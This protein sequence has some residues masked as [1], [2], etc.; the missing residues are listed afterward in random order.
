MRLTAPRLAR[1]AAI[2]LS[3]SQAKAYL[4]LLDL[5]P[6]R[7]GDV[8]R[9]A[10][11]PRTR[12]YAVFAELHALGLVD[13]QPG[14]PVLYAARTL[15]GYLRRRAGTLQSEA[16]KLEAELPSLTREFAP[17]EEG[18][19]RPARTRFF[20]GRASALESVAEAIAQ[21]RESIVLGCSAGTLER[22]AAAQL[23]RALTQRVGEGLQLDVVLPPRGGGRDPLAGFSMPGV[24]LRRLDT[25]MPIEIWLL[26]GRG[27]L[28]WAPH[29][30]DGEVIE[31]E[32]EGLVSANAALHTFF[33]SALR[34]AKAPER[35]LRE[36]AGF[37]P[38]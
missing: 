25:A 30:D 18:R 10:G 28:V 27:V 9:A 5:G 22:L 13:Q 23:D 36:R 11:V 20:K 21:A 31:G 1:L 17:V 4:A 6:S 29:P 24:R 3:E 35:R 14:E 33:A 32:D 26:D 38:A 7:I 15:E 19:A 8:A 34:D 12:M 16:A 37:P 2:G